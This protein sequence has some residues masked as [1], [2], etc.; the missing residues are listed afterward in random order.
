[1][2][3]HQ[4]TPYVNSSFFCTFL[5]QEYEEAVEAY[6]RREDMKSL[7]NLK[8]TRSIS[9]GAPDLDKE[10]PVFKNGGSLRD[11]QREVGVVRGCPA[12]DFP[13]YPSLWIRFAGFG[14]LGFG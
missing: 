2:A 11:Y 6:K 14:L 7:K 1:M 8:A 5:P 9:D 13:G 12:T 10:P 4:N 3:A